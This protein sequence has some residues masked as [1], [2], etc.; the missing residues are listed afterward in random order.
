[1]NEIEILKNRIELLENVIANWSFSDR[2]VFQKNLQLMDGRNIQLARGTGTKIGTATDQK[3]AFYGE[4]PVVQAASISN[5]SGGS[6]QDSESR[7][8]IIS[9]LTA[10]RNIGIIA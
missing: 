6:T 3:L 9:I 2:Y 4:T 5:P 1:M 8:A 7:T 10:L